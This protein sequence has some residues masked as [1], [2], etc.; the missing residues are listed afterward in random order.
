VEEQIN[1]LKKLMP[2]L[3]DLRILKGISGKAK[4]I[5]KSHSLLPQGL[6]LDWPQDWS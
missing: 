3:M 5:N 4:K 1:R 2:H 6:V